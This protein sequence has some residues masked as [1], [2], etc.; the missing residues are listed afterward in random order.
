VAKSA[1]ERWRFNLNSDEISLSELS[2]ADAMRVAREIEQGDIVA[3]SNG[4]CIQCEF[5]STHAVVLYMGR[6]GVILCPYL[7]DWPTVIQDFAP[8]FCDGCG[9]RLGTNEGYLARFFDREMGFRLFEAV[10]CGPPLPDSMPATRPDQPLFPG[11]ESP[12]RRPLEWRPLP[13]SGP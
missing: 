12:A 10:L 11:F 7:P 9:I 2:W 3:K 8:F 1:L 13:G 6:D 4:E 5:N